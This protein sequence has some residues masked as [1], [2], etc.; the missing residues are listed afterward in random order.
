MSRRSPKAGL[1]NGFWLDGSG[2]KVRRI[3][4]AEYPELYRLWRRHADIRLGARLLGM[5]ASWHRAECELCGNERV[6]A[7]GPC[8][9]CCFVAAADSGDVA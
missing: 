4:R 3:Q 5:A 6:R 9:S 8:A 7:S 1:F 2:E